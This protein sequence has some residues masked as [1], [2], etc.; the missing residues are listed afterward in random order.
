MT[1]KLSCAQSGY[2]ETS[3]ICVMA[4]LCICASAVG[5]L[6]NLISN[7]TDLTA[8]ELAALFI[9]FCVACAYQN[10]IE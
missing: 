7:Q 6:S 5:V 8:L 2:I 1:C 3:D 10:A 9:T 4:G